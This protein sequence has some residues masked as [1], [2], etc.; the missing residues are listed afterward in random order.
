MMP[1]EP[2][3]PQPLLLGQ[4]REPLSTALPDLRGSTSRTASAFNRSISSGVRLVRCPSPWGVAGT[5]SVAGGSGGVGGGNRLSGRLGDRNRHGGTAGDSPGGFRNR[6]GRRSPGTIVG[7][8]VRPRELHR[9]RLRRSAC[10]GL[11]FQRAD[12]LR[13]CASLRPQ[14]P[15]PQQQGRLP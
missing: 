2:E 12:L 7:A 15:G 3:M 10:G 8:P 9:A 1:P 6:R 13:V 4:V 11:R 14:A 5:A